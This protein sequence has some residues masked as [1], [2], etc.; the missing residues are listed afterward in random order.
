L[1][2][3]AAQGQIFYQIRDMVGP[4]GARTIE[5][6]IKGASNKQSGIVA[7][8]VGLVTLLFGATSVVAELRYSMNVVWDVP[9]DPDAGIKDIIKEKSYALALVLGCGFLLLVSLVVSAAIAAAGKF[10]R[11]WLPLP[12]SLLAIAN[13]S[14]LGSS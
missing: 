13:S 5:E 7:S 11:T 10:M 9:A 2:L 4:E 14:L 6:M 3:V 8:L 12:E 1:F